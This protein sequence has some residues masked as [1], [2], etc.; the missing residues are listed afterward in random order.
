MFHR[1]HIHPS[2]RSSL[3]WLHLQTSALTSYPCK[4]F[5]SAITSRRIV[6][7]A[8]QADTQLAAA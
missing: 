8:E 4:Q 7:A 6:A 5:R 2:R 3:N 1:D